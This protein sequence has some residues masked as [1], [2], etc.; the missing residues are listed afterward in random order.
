MVNPS[1]CASAD[2]LHY[3]YYSKYRFLKSIHLHHFSIVIV[4]FQVS[5]ECRHSAVRVFAAANVCPLYSFSINIQ[6]HLP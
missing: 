5:L 1:A 4:M 3:I 6:I 2:E